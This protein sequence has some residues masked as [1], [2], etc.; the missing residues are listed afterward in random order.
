[1]P[2]GAFA[3]ALQLDNNDLANLGE[4]IRDNPILTAD[5]AF[6]TSEWSGDSDGTWARW[7]TVSINSDIGWRQ[8]DNSLMTDGANPSF[9]GSWD[10]ANWGAN[11]QRTISWDLGQL[12][13]PAELEALA[14]SSFV[15]LNMALN[16]DGAFDTAG[17]SYWIDNIR[18]GS[19]QVPEPT[20]LALLALG[21]LLM[22]R[23]RS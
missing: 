3:W 2:P 11:H 22:G 18:L 5:V 12:Y 8:T 17:G 10:Q 13:T 23:R 15:Q 19:G 16:Y 21:G 9:P 6:V 1:A 14:T 20:S 7:D 4:L